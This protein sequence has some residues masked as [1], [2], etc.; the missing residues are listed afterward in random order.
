MAAMQPKRSLAVIL[1][2]TGFSTS[3]TNMERWAKRYCDEG[4]VLR[5]RQVIE[6]LNAL[7]PTGCEYLD[8]TAVRL[9]PSATRSRGGA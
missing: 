9:Y 3:S 1:S 8:W 2:G 5:R 7:P 4:I 6:H